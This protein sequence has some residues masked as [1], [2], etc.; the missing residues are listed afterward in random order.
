MPSARAVA[1][2]T[3]KHGDG[4]RE[5]VGGEAEAEA[6]EAEEEDE[7]EMGASAPERRMPQSRSSAAQRSILTTE[8]DEKRQE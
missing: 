7:D 2:T 6:A 8:E 4:E 3:S 1:K 5:H